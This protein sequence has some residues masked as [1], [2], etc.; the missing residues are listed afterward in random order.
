MNTVDLFV[1][2]SLMTFPTLFQSRS[3]VLRYIFGVG[4]TGYEFVGGELVNGCPNDRDDSKMRY[5]DLDERETKIKEDPTY[6]GI[7]DLRAME[8][9][10]IACERATRKLREENIDVVARMTRANN[11]DYTYQQLQN[12]WNID[13]IPVEELNDEWLAAF[14]EFIEIMDGSISRLFNLYYDKPVRGE[15]APEPSMFSRMPAEWQKRYTTVKEIGDR[16]EA[17]TGK[18]ARKAAMVKEMFANRSGGNQ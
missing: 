11:R 14:E 12:L 7:E 16:I 10:E 9:Y 13:R 18:K 8:L 5:D 6:A 3:D 4:G 2:K 17:R 1:R 15:K